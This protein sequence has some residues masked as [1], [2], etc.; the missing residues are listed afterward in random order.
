MLGPNMINA[1]D[2]KDSRMSFVDLSEEGV[3]TGIKIK[4][5]SLTPRD[6]GAKFTYSY[7]D[8]DLNKDTGAYVL[9]IID[10]EEE[11]Q[12]DKEKLFVKLIYGCI[13]VVVLLVVVTTL[14]HLVKRGLVPLYLCRRHASTKRY[15][16]TKDKEEE[17]MDDNSLV[18]GGDQVV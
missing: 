3:S 1:E 5:D 12:R 6:D 7:I 11:R 10:E 18:P 16:F 15:S 13:I 8:D 4:L 14:V 9:S 2:V 17:H